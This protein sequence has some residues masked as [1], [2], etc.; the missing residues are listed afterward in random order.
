MSEEFTYNASALALGGVLNVGPYGSRTRTTLPSVASVALSPTG[1]EGWAVQERFES[2]GILFNYALSKVSGYRAPGGDYVTSTEV[3]IDGLNIFDRLRIASMHAK[4]V[5]RHTVSGSS[6]TTVN[7]SY[8]RVEI[9][10]VEIEPQ[11]DFAIGAP[12]PTFDLVKAQL[13]ANKTT[14]AERFG[15]DEPTMDSVLASP[16]PEV[17]GSLTSN[18]QR[19]SPGPAM[20]APRKAYGLQIANLGHA[21]FAEYHVKPGRRRVTLLRLD[22]D[23][24]EQFHGD[25]HR[26][27]PWG[28]RSA[29]AKKDE[30]DGT[31][32]LASVEGNGSPPWKP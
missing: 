22:L 24:L 12:A 7:A 25:T 20:M 23:T 27:F 21:H 8:E 19:V 18:F 1:G 16:A 11:L 3:T 6:F 13:L 28:T 14:Y 32:T 30:L 26:R 2:N 10:G 9:D 29:N 4:V 17:R 5:S 15:V 31:V